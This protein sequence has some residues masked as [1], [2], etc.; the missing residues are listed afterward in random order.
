MSGNYDRQLMSTAD[1]EVHYKVDKDFQ[2][3]EMHSHDFFEV[4]CFLRGS[5]SY[6]VE[7]CKYT[8][9]PGDVLLIPQGKLHQLDIKDSAETYERYVLWINAKYMKKISSP[10]TDL[11]TCFQCALQ[12]KSFLIRNG[13]TSQKVRRLLEGATLS[14]RDAFGADIE[15]EERIKSLLVTLAQFFLQ[16]DEKTFSYGTSNA[17]VS[18]AI[19]YISENI[20]KDLSLDSIASAL[21]VNKYYLAHVF[22]QTTNTS[23]HRYILKK[24]LV[25]SKQLLEKGHPSTEVY[26]K[27]GFTDYTHFFRA[28]KNEFG[29][30]PK[31]FV[32]SLR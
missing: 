20:D 14:Q 9:L 28:F 2:A 18:R 22:K 27:C 7:D 24:R 25:L 5:A 3:V 17:C 6:I 19:D 10:Q 26:S 4:Y 1:F 32:K 11:R 12:S 21:F 13:S 31:Q 16:N 30:T 15:N 29:I 8:L 23:P